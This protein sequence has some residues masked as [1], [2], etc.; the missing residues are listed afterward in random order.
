MAFINGQK[1]VNDVAQQLRGEVSARIE[2]HLLDFLKIP[3]E[4]NQFNIT[5]LQQNWAYANDPK[6]LQEYFLAQVKTHETITSI[7]FGNKNGGIIGSGREGNN[8]TFYVYNTKDL[9]A[10]VFNKYA[11]TNSG[12]VGELLTSIPHLDTRTRSWYDRASKKGTATWSDIYILFTR[13]DMAISASSPV[14]DD[15][16]KL[17]GVVSVDISLSQIE[18]F[19]DTLKFSPSG[20]IFI[21]ERSGLLVATSTGEQPFRVTNDKLER[22]N[23]S[24]IQTP[25]VRYAAEFLQERFGENFD[26]SNKKQL[27]FE[28]GGENYFLDISPVQDQYGIDW[29]IVVVIPESDFMAEIKNTNRTT[30]QIVITAL[31]ISILISFFIARKIAGRISILNNAARAFAKNEGKT[32]TLSNSRIREIDELTISFIEMERQLHQTLNDLKTEVEERKLIERALRES[33]ALFRAIFEQ[34]A[35]GICTLSLDGKFLRVNQRFADII[36]YKHKDLLG[37]TFNDITHTED[38]SL[39]LKNVQML[40]NNVNNG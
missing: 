38:L 3:H 21:M 33:E 22:L 8:G 27:E 20:Q 16:H 15:H 24:E 17:L 11:I 4:I 6:M 23:I 35:V 26:I 25:V 32:T 39:N 34:A 2:D 1:A 37:L 31:V 29:L 12:T 19:L 30:A 10:G 13:Q 14:Y 5:S 9:K 7:Y 40:L 28:F 18:K 36:G